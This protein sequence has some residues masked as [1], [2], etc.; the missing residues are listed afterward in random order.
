MIPQPLVSICIA[1]LSLAYK[2]VLEELVAYARLAWQPQSPWTPLIGHLHD[3]I[4]SMSLAVLTFYLLWAALSCQTCCITLH[5]KVLF[6]LSKRRVRPLEKRTPRTKAI[7]WHLLFRSAI[8]PSEKCFSIRA[9]HYLIHAASL[10]RHHNPSLHHCHTPYSATPSCPNFPS[11]VSS[12]M[13]FVWWCWPDYDEWG[14]ASQCESGTFS[15]VILLWMQY[16]IWVHVYVH[17][18]IH[19]TQN[20]YIHEQSFW[21]II[22]LLYKARL[23]SRPRRAVL[24][25]P[26]YCFRVATARDACMHGMYVSIDIENKQ[27]HKP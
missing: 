5:C 11:T 6:L 22:L 8:R 19:Y 27:S 1:L 9:S 4:Y 24:G 2:S 16:A 13:I 21:L 14:G 17:T 25:L 12:V 23:V 15:G 26:C 20:L 10:P 7:N 3:C 18:Y